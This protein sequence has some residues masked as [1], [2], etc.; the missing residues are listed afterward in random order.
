MEARDWINQHNPKSW[1]GVTVKFLRDVGLLGK[2][3]NKGKS[4]GKKAFTLTDSEDVKLSRKREAE[5][6]SP[7]DFK[8]K[9]KMHNT[10]KS[11]ETRYNRKKEK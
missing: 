9:L 6:Q 3:L 10:Y 5:E 8:M 4:R 11:A 2:P 7:G 1:K